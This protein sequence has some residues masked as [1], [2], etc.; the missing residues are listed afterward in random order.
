MGQ[1]IYYDFGMM[2]LLWM[3]SP[4]GS[5]VQAAAA[6]D[7]AALVEEMGRE[8]PVELMSDRCGVWCG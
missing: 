4:T 1:L 6:R 7:S 5:M 2:G 8:D 3:P